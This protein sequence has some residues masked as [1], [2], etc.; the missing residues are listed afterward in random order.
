MDR[1]MDPEV[2]TDIVVPD[3]II[4]EAPDMMEVEN[5]NETVNEI[6]TKFEGAPEQVRISIK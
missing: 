3:E 1:D 5:N 2:E 4:P 6:G